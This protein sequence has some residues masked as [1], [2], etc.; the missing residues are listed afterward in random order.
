MMEAMS[1]NQQADIGASDGNAAKLSSRERLVD[2]ASIEFAEKGFGG[3]SIRE[4]CKRAETSSN[5]IHH[6]FGSKQG[7]YDELLSSLSEEVFNTPIRIIQE[8]AKSR[9]NMIARLELF[10]EETLE[11]LIARANTYRLVLR[12][13]TV[14]DVF[15]NYNNQFVAFLDSGKAA[16]FVRPELD[17]EMLTGLILDR[18]GNQIVYASWIKETVGQNVMTDGSYK[19]RWLAANLDFILHGI[20]V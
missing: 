15:E 13:Q 4:I 9:E 10:I 19:K 2:A 3:A 5:M 8:P 14:L 6:Y 7:L 16:G 17:S 1:K 18:L 20:L 12:E 11:A